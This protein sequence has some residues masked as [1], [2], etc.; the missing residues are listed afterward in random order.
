MP[1]SDGRDRSDDRDPDRDLIAGIRKGDESAFEKLFRQYFESLLQFGIR[2]LQHREDAEDAV[3]TVFLNIWKSRTVFHP[4][5]TLK[6]YLFAATRNQCLKRMRHADVV[7]K[8]R[9][10]NIF[11]EIKTSTPET[12]LIHKELESRISDAILSLPEKCRIIFCMNRF[13]GLTYREIAVI[14]DLSLSTVE[15]QMVRALKKLRNE[16]SNSGV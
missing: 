12:D 6:A 7:K 3:Q 5:Y 10:G 14:Q 15:T 9:A 1:T 4:R 8:Y 11:S 13:D 16:L 2:Y